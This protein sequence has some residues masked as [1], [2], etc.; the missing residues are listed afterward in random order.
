MSNTYVSPSSVPSTPNLDSVAAREKDDPPTAAK[1]KDASTATY[2]FNVTSNY[3]APN[4]VTVEPVK[5]RGLA[6]NQRRMFTPSDELTDEQRKKRKICYGVGAFVI[7]SVVIGLVVSSL[8]KVENTEYGLQYDIHAKELDDA[9]KSGG[10]FLGP[11]GH[12]FVKFP[13]TF[14]TVDLDERIC[15]SYDGLLVNFSVTF[16]YKMTDYNLLP[17]IEK[18][19]DY[20]KWADTVEEAGLS[21]IHH[22]CSEFQ[23]T[24]FQSKRGIIQDRMLDNLKLKLQGDESGQ[25][26]VNAE[27]VSLQLRFVGLPLAYN[28]AVAEKQSAEEDIAVAIAQRKQET[29]KADTQLLQAKEEARRIIDTANNEAEVLLTEALLQAEETLFAFEK[30]ADALL[31]VKQSL[32]FTTEGVLAYLSNML[33]N[34]SPSLS[35]TT[36]EPVRMSRK[37][38]L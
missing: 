24:E 18:Y 14:I 21:A 3:A 20:G 34:E 26:G 6:S 25:D 27:A 37:E 22:S 30:E 31:E 5:E 16:Q 8:S 17:A 19:R 32:N 11:P 23:V 33:I 15:V 36:E 13:S 2:S 1:E 28:D 7:L 29:T 10:L 12:R 38:G 4:Q 35:V 9:A